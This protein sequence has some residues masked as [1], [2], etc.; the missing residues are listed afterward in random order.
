MSNKGKIQ[1]IEIIM[2]LWNDNRSA[3]EIGRELHITRNAV[4][5]RV[6]R[7]RKAGWVDTK[8]KVIPK[9]TRRAIYFQRKEERQKTSNIIKKN[10]QE[11]RINHKYLANGK[12]IP[13]AKKEYRKA[14]EPIE[15]PTNDP[16][17]IWDINIDSCR[18]IVSEVDG[19][20]TLY[21]GA[22]IHRASFCPYHYK[23]CY[24]SSKQKDE[25]A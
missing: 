15:P 5:G 6:N 7:A 25:A 23:L 22:M 2:K 9:E 8:P 13:F 19:K 20:D 17:Y 1:D 4:I 11:R 10:E 24:V 3:T 21:C 16:V 18:Y 14:M 12:S